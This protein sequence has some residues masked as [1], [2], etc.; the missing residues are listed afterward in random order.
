[1]SNGE[2]ID[3]N[4]VGHIGKLSFPVLYNSKSIA[5]IL[6]MSEVAKER[7][8]TTLLWRMLFGCIAMMDG[9]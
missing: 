7:R 6:L 5:N 3:C 4:Q 2:T 9:F 8:L 1:M